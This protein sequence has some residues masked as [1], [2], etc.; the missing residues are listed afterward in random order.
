ME[1]NLHFPADRNSLC[2]SRTVTV[3]LD[4]RNIPFRSVDI[5]D[6]RSDPRNIILFY[7][8]FLFFHRY[9]RDATMLACNSCIHI[10]GTIRKRYDHL[11]FSESVIHGDHHMILVFHHLYIIDIITDLLQ[12]GGP[13]HL[14]IRDIHPGCPR[15]ADLCITV[16]ANLGIFKIMHSPD[17]FLSDV[18]ISVLS[19]EEDQRR[20]IF[21]RIPLLRRICLQAKFRNGGSDPDP[22]GN[23]FPVICTYQFI[24]SGK[25]LYLFPFLHDIF[26]INIDQMLHYFRDFWIKLASRSFHDLLTDDLLRHGISITPVGGHGIICICYSNDPCDL[27]NILAFSSFRI[28]L[29]VIAF[30]MVVRP[31]TEERILTDSG[32]DFLSDTRMF[33]NLLILIVCQFSVF[34]Q[35]PV[36]DTDLTYI[37]Q[38]TRIVDPCTLILA[39]SHGFG[40]LFGILRH[41]NGMTAGIFILCID[42]TYQGGYGLLKQT[43]GSLF[44]L[45]QLIHFNLLII[46]DLLVSPVDDN[47]RRNCQDISEETGNSIQ[48]MRPDHTYENDGK[49]H[50]TEDKGCEK[51][52]LSQ[53]HGQKDTAYAGNG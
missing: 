27:R 23:L 9:I 53:I 30:M 13:S 31:Y 41:T 18:N 35:N 46:I 22:V 45:F 16:K 38:K 2:G 12:N 32:Q 47:D 21:C 44:L 6:L 14:N 1:T 8:Y 4:I 36:C 52:H 49:L 37:M 29:S 40:N 25:F 39:L 34:R 17:Q 7:G 11:Y 24:L 33:F 50:Q 48:V 26:F 3:N 51:P 15:S 42:G 5:T 28:A 19:I 43:S 10:S 20:K